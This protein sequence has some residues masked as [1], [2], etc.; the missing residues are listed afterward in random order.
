MT[1]GALVVAAFIFSQRNA[2]AR[3]EESIVLAESLAEDG[4]FENV[5]VALEAIK[6]GAPKPELSDR[7]WVLLAEAHTALGEEDLA[8]HNWQHLADSASQP[9]LRGRG[10]LEMANA[11]LEDGDAEA[12]QELVDRF[13]DQGLPGLTDHLLLLQGRLAE[14]DGNVEKAR[15]LL[16]DALRRFPRTDV[17]DE[18][19]SVLSDINMDLLM[20]R[21][22]REGD[23]LYVIAQSD[24]LDALGR[25]FEVSPSLIQRVNGI[26]DPRRLRIGQRIKI[27]RSDFHIE[28]YKDQFKVAVFDNGDFFVSYPCRIGREEYMTPI[29]TFHVESRSAD[30]VWNDPTT[31]RTVAAGDQDNE[32]GTRWLG[33]RE[34]ASLGIHGTIHPESIGS[35]ASNGC[36]GLLTEDVEEL[37]DL[38]PRGTEVR[39]Y[40]TRAEAMRENSRGSSSSEN[41]ESPE[42]T[43]GG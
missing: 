39:I 4:E 21:Q 10:L 25:R 7:V 19:E 6:E 37:Y 15:E 23:E 29:G 35:P 14:A 36:I 43:S 33:F 30:P 26:T 18:I 17:R 24:T 40:Q 34:N 3:A 8:R 22:P 9:I 1:V 12:A 28:V 16:T 42:E 13:E 32:L 38:I 2:A 5:V 20:S 27:P 31:G 41:S 11:D